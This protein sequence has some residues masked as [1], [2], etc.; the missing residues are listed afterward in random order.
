M[1]HA[2]LTDATVKGLLLP[3]VPPLSGLTDKYRPEL[4]PSVHQGD[5]VVVSLHQLLHLVK[6][7]MVTINATSRAQKF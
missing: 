2:T 7:S 4:L 6:R 1:A 5:L 3:E